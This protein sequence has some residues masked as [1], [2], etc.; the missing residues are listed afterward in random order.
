[1]LLFMINI[2]DTIFVSNGTYKV[3]FNTESGEKRLIGKPRKL[4]AVRSDGTKIT[5]LLSL[6]EAFTGGIRKFFATMRLEDDSKHDEQSLKNHFENTVDKALIAAT[7]DIKAAL[8][9]EMQNLLAEMEKLKSKNKVLK[10][11]NKD[12]E[13]GLQKVAEDAASPRK[14]INLNTIQI[15]D[16]F[17]NV[18][19][20]GAG[21]TR[22]L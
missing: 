7:S 16:R 1:M 8:G 9:T 6:G 20:S 17:A 5:I 13:S 3:T 4:P 2:S 21:N 22:H 11:K 18:G 12:M 10:S 19:G 14:T 15:H